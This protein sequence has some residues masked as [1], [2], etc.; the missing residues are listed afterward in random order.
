MKIN[1][2]LVKLS[3]LVFVSLAMLQITG[4]SSMGGYGSNGSPSGY[5]NAHSISDAVPKAEPRGKYG[6]PTSYRVGRQRYY[7]MKDA[8]GYNKKGYA[9]WYGS[10]FHGRRTSSR[11]RYDMYSMTAAS[12]TLPIPTYV[13]VTN[14]ENGRSVIVKVNDRGPFH[15]KRIIDLSYAAAKK[16]G[17]AHKGTAYV[18]VTAIGSL[19]NNKLG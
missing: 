5:F 18:H 2:L 4:C 19:S 12:T 13:R 1:R 8:S 7:V 9:S 15:S 17:Y 11:E 14:L 10:Q 16:L 6:N 3:G